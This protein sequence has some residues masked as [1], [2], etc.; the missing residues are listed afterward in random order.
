MNW[1]AMITRAAIVTAILS[2]CA[3]FAVA[4][5]RDTQPENYAVFVS[6]RGGAAELY[7]INLESRQ[8]SQLTE[9]GRGH[10]AAS[11]APANRTIVYAAREGASYELFCG[12]VS[13]AWR[14]RRP[15]ITALTRLTINTTEEISPSITADGNWMA[16]ASG[17]GIELMN[18][19]DQSRRVL[20]PSAP[21]LPTATGV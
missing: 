15:A 10:L 12:K 16:F 21:S 4:Q 3:T 2:A 9:T 5:A 11:I 8:V 17:N 13:A 6:Q 7:L 19:G 18:L 1:K 20:A 14:A